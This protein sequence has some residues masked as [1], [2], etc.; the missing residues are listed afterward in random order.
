MPWVQGPLVTT[1]IV[2]PQHPTVTIDYALT[3]QY[4]AFVLSS[5]TVGL[6][7]ARLVTASAGSFTLTPKTATLAAARL[8]TASY[9]AFTLTQETST[10]VVARTL[11]ASYGAFAL[12]PKTAARSSPHFDSILRIVYVHRR[13]RDTRIDTGGNK[14]RI[15]GP[16]RCIHSYP[17]DSR[18]H[19]RED[20]HCILWGFYAHS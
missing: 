2:A 16:V 7:V 11:T 18:A 15:D 8:L 13:V 20:C 19:S 4:G 3:G 1:H 17:K 5:Q 10:L 9:G 14:L 6:A 12:T